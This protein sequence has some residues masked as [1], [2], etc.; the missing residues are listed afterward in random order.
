MKKY[1]R[2]PRV[3]RAVS[4]PPYTDRVSTPP[5]LRP[6]RDPRAV[7]RGRIVIGALAAVLVIAV[8]ATLALLAPHPRSSA[9]PSGSAKPSTSA[10]ASGTP[11]AS[12][13]PSAPASG[14]A[15]DASAKSIDDPASD[16]VVVNK[17]RP[18]NP[19]D[20]AP[21]LQAL[22]I[23]GA[24]G[25]LRMRPD[26]ATAVDAMAAQYKSETGQGLNSQSDYRPYA[27]Q[28]RVY[29]G[30]VASKGQAQADLQSAR[31]G[32]S[33][34][35]TGLAIDFV[36]T[37]GGCGLAACFADTNAGT[38]LAQN[39]YKWGFI[40]RYPE[41]KTAVTGYEF[42]P[43]HYR[44]VG[45]DLATE[46]HDTGVSTMEEFFHLPAAPDYAS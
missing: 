40:L 10:S 13:T 33:E 30:W 6:R 23:G 24:G 15:F 36:G 1:A 5:P 12:S 9:S 18:L 20:Y 7:L 17:I 42:E 8:V 45:V 27:S 3:S 4:T 21:P 41:G 37:T 46:M 26:A 11:S 22:H 43:W 29:N 14:S 35:Q 25:A 44:Y 28:V 2:L 31:P 39:A 34:H 19:K 16:W 38:W 32:Y